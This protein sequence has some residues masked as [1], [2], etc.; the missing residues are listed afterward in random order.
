MLKIDGETCYA[1]RMEIS[2]DTMLTVAE[3]AKE[4]GLARRTVQKRVQTGLMK[5]RNMHGHL[6][7]IPRA[8]VERLRG[9][10]LLPRGRKPGP[11]PSS[12]LS[13]GPGKK[14]GVQDAE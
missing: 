7:L 6:W 3:T 14:E 5:G 13:P 11:G 9:V 12:V 2:D 8:E 1:G 4:L 10:G